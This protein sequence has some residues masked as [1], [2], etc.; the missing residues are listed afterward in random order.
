[1]VHRDNSN[2][3]SFTPLVL[4]QPSLVEVNAAFV[5]LAVL[6]AT[7]LLVVGGVLF[8]K[9]QDQKSRDHDRRTYTLA[10]PADLSMD[11]VTAWT[12]SISGTLTGPSR[13]LGLPTTAIELWAN[14]RGITHR[15]RVS[16]KQADY[17]V[18]QLRSLLPGVKI[19]PEDTPP[20]HEWTYAVELGMTHPSRP[21]RIYNA[22]SV[23]TSLLATVQ[24]LGA[25][26]QVIM[27]WVVAP[28]TPQKPPPEHQP[29]RRGGIHPNMFNEM[30]RPG[31]D[32]V[33]EQRTKLAEPNLQAVLRIAAKAETKHQAKHLVGNVHAALSSVR[34]PN[35]SFRRR[36]ISEEAAVARTAKASGSLLFPIQLSASELASLIA[37]PIGSPYIAGL[38][39]GHSRHLP[40]NESISRTGI[41]IAT[42]NFPGSERLLAVSPVD[43]CKHFHVCGQTGVGKTTFLEGVVAQNIEAGHGVI[44]IEPKGD[45][46]NRV[47]DHVPERRLSDVVILDVTDMAHPVGFNI[48]AE[49]RPETV[50]SDLYG[51]FTSIYGRQGVRVPEALYHGLMTLMTSTAAT[52][53]MTFVDLVPLFS[54]LTP[55][56]K[57]FS[58][59]LIRGVPDPYIR[60]FWQ[61]VDNLSRTQRDNF[62]GP[63]KERI[64]Q[65]NNRAVIRNIIG[66]STS[67]F[68]IGSV[69]RGEKILL[70]NLVGL[71]EEVASLVGTL[72]F[73]AIWNAVVSGATNPAHPTFLYLDEFQSFMNL[74][75]SFADITAKARGFGLSLWLSH[76]YM[77]QLPIELRAGMT[78]TRNKV[79]FQTGSDDAAYFAREFG[80]SV[81]PED[82][83]H[84]GFRE[85]I[86]RLAG[87]TGVGAPV[88]GTTNEPP[89]LQGLAQAVRELS[90]QTYGR[91]AADVEAE[92][93]ARRSSVGGG[94]ANSPEVKPRQWRS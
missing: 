89:K 80:R 61:S 56:E 86:M 33:S 87:E 7:G 14:D 3:F 19:M 52:M 72:I 90:R 82:F 81:K 29:K 42:S 69:L 73:N 70:V 1:M 65:L 45:L 27:Q 34:S 37:W 2:R 71:G 94:T 91:P 11:Q 64:W 59:A 38:P 63:I 47:L 50:A 25:G 40:A 26:E 46:F 62:F 43:A 13:L 58:D 35:N 18:P 32:I 68:D 41:Q 48:L 76:Q 74:P 31:K 6:L 9:Q 54:P 44:I 66:Q 21:L 49:G 8:V 17:V 85:V 12:H 5:F 78:N 20:E 79:I 57:N 55:E 30:F 22:E 77:G 28:A 67:S 36:W 10:F 75:V 15:I 93:N 53:P 83:M 24:S 4:P 16:R 88:T 39:T 60:N 92:I 51:V 84:L 23:A